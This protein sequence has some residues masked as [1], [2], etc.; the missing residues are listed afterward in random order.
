[1][2]LLFFSLILTAWTWFK[3][4]FLDSSFSFCLLLPDLDIGKTGI[5]S[6]T[7]PSLQILFFHFWFTMNVSQYQRDT[8]ICL[9][10]WLRTCAYIAF[11]PYVFYP[12]PYMSKLL[13]VKVLIFSVSPSTYFVIY[14][15]K[16]SSIWANFNRVFEVFQG[17]LNSALQVMRH[18]AP[19]QSDCKIFTQQYLWWEC[20]VILYF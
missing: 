12:R 15:E 19:I 20:M 8:I 11:C 18:N 5:L 16:M 10:A 7:S 13:A 2:L 17:L 6:S 4:I 14:S 9:Y 1:M 3:I